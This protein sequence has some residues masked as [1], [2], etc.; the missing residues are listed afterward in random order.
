[1]K[2]GRPPLDPADRTV[3]VTIGLPRKQFDAY[4]RQALRQGV[5][6]PEVIRRYL[7]RPVNKNSR[8]PHT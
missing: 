8:K 2:R 4:C 1:M 7:P 6:L 3:P 5:S